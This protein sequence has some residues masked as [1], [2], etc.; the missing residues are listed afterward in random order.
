MDGALGVIHK[1][2]FLLG[3]AR[4]VLNLEEWADIVYGWPLKDRP[5]EILVLYNRIVCRGTA[6]NSRQARKQYNR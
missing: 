3:G 6:E 2:R 5:F 4:G 1:Q